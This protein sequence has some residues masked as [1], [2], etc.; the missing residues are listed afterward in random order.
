M[1]ES[2]VRLSV[3]DSS[4]NAKIKAAARAFSDFG[5]RVASAGVDA[6]K[7]FATGA[8]TAKAAFQG[9][10][11]ALKANA[12]VFVI[13]TAIQA[14]QA[15][16]EMVGDWISGANDAEDAQ[17]KLNEE[18]EKTSE[19]IKEIDHQASFN[20]RLARAAG[21]ST[22]EILRQRKADAERA[23]DIAS[24][25]AAKVAG[26]KNATQEAI[27]KAKKMVKAAEDRLRKAN[28]DIIVDN[29][30]RLNKTGEYAVRGG[31]GGRSS[32][33]L[34]IGFD[35]NK[36]AKAAVKPEDVIG[37]SDAWSALT[38]SLAKDFE[39]PVSPL[40]KLNE[41]LK[42]MKAN[43]ENAPDTQS[44]QQGLSLIA[45]K[46]KEIA[47]FKGQTD[48]T[49]IAKDAEDSWRGAASAMSAVGSALSSIEDPAAKV[50]GI[51]AQAVATVAM[52]FSQALAEDKT[53]TGN[54]W[55]FIAAAAASTAAMITMIANIHSA[56]GFAQGGMVQGNTYSGDM[57]PIR[58][59]A[60]EVVLT[61]AM[62]GNL[63]SQLE[64]NGLGNLN[65]SA[66]ISGEQIRL[67][68]NNNGRRTGRGEYVQTNFR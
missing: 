47:R 30:A 64:G 13:T 50:F 37:P 51:V 19:L 2:I 1:S 27:D 25:Q 31:G 65:L 63:A 15:I 29:A 56:T 53:T 49:T 14:A 39:T 32:K 11:A 44:Y 24:S 38:Q 9:F 21:A 26:D 18:L 40:Q 42:E 41:E 12:L 45:E 33:P 55:A 3:E 54:I 67:A 22:T 61:R 43:L 16:G 8:E 35:I 6:F 58:A 5:A 20:E 36:A 60:G 52:G 68:L 23:L 4:F 62:Q 17:R 59:N 46:E 10:N 57:V 34:K 28:E 66:T 48:T 7:K